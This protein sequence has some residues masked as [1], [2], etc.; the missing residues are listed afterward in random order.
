VSY[1]YEISVELEL[2][3][4]MWAI[5]MRYQLSFSWHTTCEL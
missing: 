3:H 5:V 4:H 1:S 2:A